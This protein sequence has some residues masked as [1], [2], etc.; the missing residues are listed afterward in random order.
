MTLQ[1]NQHLIRHFLKG[2]KKANN[3]LDQ[4]LSNIDEELVDILTNLEQNGVC[5]IVMSML[6]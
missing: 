2:N 6:W 1:K 4:N 3:I 5:F